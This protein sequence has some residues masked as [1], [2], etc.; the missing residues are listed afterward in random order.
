MI[1]ANAA[2]DPRTLRVVIADDN[3]DTVLTLG[4]LLRSESY[5]VRLATSGSEA[6]SLVED[7]RPDVV[8]LDIAMPD[9]SGLQIALEL[10]RK[11][12]PR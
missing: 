9:R 8:L 5:D 2:P 6:I 4:I 1:Q 10:N 11:Y 3:R 12:G 7:F